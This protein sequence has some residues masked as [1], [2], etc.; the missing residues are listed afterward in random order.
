MTGDAKKAT[1]ATIPD[2]TVSY[3]GYLAFLSE[4]FTQNI[5]NK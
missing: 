1:P 4:C 3:S 5:I 2:F